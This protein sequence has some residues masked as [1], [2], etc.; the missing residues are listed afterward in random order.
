MTVA[1]YIVT[2]LVALWV[3]F[4]SFS[5]LTRKD[6]VVEPLAQYGVPR[7]WWT[8]LGLAKGAGALG[9]IVGLFLPVIGVAAAIGL[10]L[11]FVGAIITALR[12]ESYK[13]APFPA[14][15]LIPV[16][17]ALTLRLAA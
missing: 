11:Y 16:A 8:P 3:A 2:V 17:A 13:T 7:S 12:A 10:I 4:S 1:Y 9:L 15:Y 14:L 5:L 6:F